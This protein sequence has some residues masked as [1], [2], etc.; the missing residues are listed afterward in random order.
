METL[1]KKVTSTCPFVANKISVYILLKATTVKDRP[2]TGL[3][4]QDCLEKSLK[5]NLQGLFWGEILRDLL[6][7]LPKISLKL[8]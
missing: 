1:Y 8:A 4:I 6:I 3:N 7:F 5:I 2:R